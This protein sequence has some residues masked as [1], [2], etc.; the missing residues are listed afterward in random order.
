[1]KN[2]IRFTALALTAATLLAA[3]A[4]FAETATQVKLEGRTQAQIRADAT[5]I[6]TRLCKAKV[7]TEDVDS[8][9]ADA[10]R[11]T[12]KRVFARGDYVWTSAD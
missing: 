5:T 8:C 1:M 6:A 12:M 4:A 3:P 9:V 10:V 2:M 11:A 7:A